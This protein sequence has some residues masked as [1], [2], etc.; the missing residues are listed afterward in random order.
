MKSSDILI[1]KIKEFEG[2]KLV[3]YKCPAGI[4][5]IGVGHTK[6]VKMGQKIQ[7]AQVNSLLRSDLSLIEVFLNKQPVKFTQGQ[8]D[9]LVDF[10]FNLGIGALSG[11]SLFKKALLKANDTEIKNEFMKWTHAAG[12]VL[13]GLVKRRQWESTRWCEK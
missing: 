10:A 2:V 4:P 6:G 1:E 3:A 11:S 13:P 7:M 12:K 5:T 9:A 8:F